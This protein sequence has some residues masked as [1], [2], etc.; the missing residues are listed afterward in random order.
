MLLNA[1]EGTG[2]YLIPIRSEFRIMKIQNITLETSCIRSLAGN[3]K[4]LPDQLAALKRLVSY[5]EEGKIR[6]WVSPK[7]ITEMW[8]RLE[9]EGQTEGDLQRLDAWRKSLNITKEFEEL[10]G[11]FMLGFSSL[12]EDTI[13]AS[14]KDAEFFNFL[15]EIAHPDTEPENIARGHYFDISNLVEHRSV[16]NDIFVTLDMHFLK[17]HIA[18]KLHADW[19]IVICNPINA[20]R[21]V[22]NEEKH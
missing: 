3:D 17:E 19:D 2:R 18:K 9:L 6:I 8:E 14:D 1:H 5:F 4:T 10:P 7:S 20:I 11:L 16:G 12:G 21:L 13:L 15:R 22:E